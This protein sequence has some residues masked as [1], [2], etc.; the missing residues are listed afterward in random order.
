MSEPS[1]KTLP[2]DARAQTVRPA[3]SDGPAPPSDRRIG[4]L[5]KGTYT[6]ERLLGAGGMG[7]VYL[8]QH[9]LI[10]KKVAIKILAPEYALKPE[11][12]ERFLRE[13]RAAAAID[14]D[15]VIEIHDFGET[16]DGTAFFVMEY[17]EGEDL[18]AV[19]QREAPLPWPR[20]Q[21]IVVQLCRALQAAHDRGIVHRDMKPG[22][23]FRLVR[24]G[25]DVIKVLDFGIAKLQNPDEGVGQ[26]LTRTGMIFG[27]PEYMS[28]EQAQGE[29]H[30]HRVDIYAV[31][32]ILFELLTGKPPFVAETFMGLL[33]KHMF[34]APPRPADVA[35]HADIPAAAEAVVLKALQKD[36]DLRFQTMD[37]LAAALL[38]VDAG[39]APEL[40]PE[41]TR[42]RPARGAPMQFRSADAPPRP[43]L[44][45]TTAPA[46]PMPFA[47]PPPRT[48]VALIAGLGGAVLAAGALVLFTLADSSDSADRTGPQEHVPP[49]SAPEL[50]PLP[51]P[52]PVPAPPPLSPDLLPL[53]PPTVT[54][55]IDTAGLAAEVLD[56]RGAV[57]GTTADPRGLQLPRSDGARLLRLR[58]AGRVEAPLKLVPSED[59]IV[60]VTLEPLPASKPTSKKATS[61]KKS[62]AKPEPPPPPVEPPPKPKPEPKSSTSP[63]LISPFKK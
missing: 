56:E 13:A 39:V 61:P 63:D 14:H 10:R 60:A 15:G 57:L 45:E 33:N 5:L 41:T 7:S 43:T 50:L 51:P 6:L 35:P 49:V 38:A 34:D 21:G 44:P 2:I 32:V 28:P 54:V 23:C 22:N 3:G 25:R 46:F 58:A 24:D 62:E 31:G 1:A 47:P 30:D 12:K 40:V 37:A 9:A 17:L 16:A 36:P 48:N 11:L 55:R 26:A 20:A 8:A 52:A 59:Q 29:R 53:A 19:I 18:A 42:A 4:D 27:T